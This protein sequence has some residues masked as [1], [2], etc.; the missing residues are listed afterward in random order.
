MHWFVTMRPLHH[1]Q[2]AII[3]PLSLTGGAIIAVAPAAAS[4]L[5]ACMSVFAAIYSPLFAALGS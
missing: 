2:M 3:I 1:H 4:D 5:V